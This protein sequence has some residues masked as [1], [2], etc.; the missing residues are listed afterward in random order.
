[1]QNQK[2]NFET[3]AIRMQLCPGSI[4]VKLVNHTRTLN[5][6]NEKHTQK[7]ETVNNE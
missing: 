6:T 4:K 1:M 3:H 7:Q 5:P 2:I